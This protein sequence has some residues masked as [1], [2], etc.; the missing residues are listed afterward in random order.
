MPSKE[1][2]IGPIVVGFELGL[3]L[4]TTLGEFF[5]VPPGEG[6]A[7]A[8][9]SPKRSSRKVRMPA[10]TPTR[11]TTAIANGIL[12]PDA[13]RID[14][15]R[16]GESSHR[17]AD[18]PVQRGVRYERCEHVQ[19]PE[20]RF[21]LAIAPLERDCSHVRRAVEPVL[22]ARPPS[23]PACREILC[24]APELLMRHRSV[25]IVAGRASEPRPRRD[26]Q[27]TE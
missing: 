11:T 14:V 4:G 27:T 7:P 26:W 17:T 23:K 3:G 18:E 10:R 1:A 19:R 24:R 16:T 20:Q 8:R 12:R 2:L 5:R 21:G 25:G 13:C 15:R 6:D 9:G 22:N